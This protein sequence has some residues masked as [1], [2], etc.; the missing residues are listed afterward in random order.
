MQV[1]TNLVDHD[2]VERHHTGSSGITA[3]SIKRGK[4]TQVW[5]EYDFDTRDEAIFLLGGLLTRILQETGD[6][7]LIAESVAFYVVQTGDT[8]PPALLK[9]KAPE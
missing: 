2:G 6:R 1:E 8:L 9:T 4:E 7:M 5:F 3:T